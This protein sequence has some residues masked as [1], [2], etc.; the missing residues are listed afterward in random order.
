[1]NHSQNGGFYLRGHSQ[2]GG[3]HLGVI[4]AKIDVDT[5][6]IKKIRKLLQLIFHLS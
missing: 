3:F 6:I 2:N 1:M 4:W 5:T